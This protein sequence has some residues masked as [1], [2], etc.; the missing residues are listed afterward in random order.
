MP[1]YSIE[2]GKDE[3]KLA[4]KVDHHSTQ[5]KDTQT[6]SESH[7]GHDQSEPEQRGN[8]ISNRSPR[9]DVAASSRFMPQAGKPAGIYD[10]DM[11]Q[12][13]EGEEKH[14][15]DHRDDVAASVPYMPQSG[16]QTKTSSL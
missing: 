7:S 8:T 9:E 13:D 11:G 6:K 14:E 10:V 5:N 16:K 3:F 2:R 4:E 15:K 12:N 1:N